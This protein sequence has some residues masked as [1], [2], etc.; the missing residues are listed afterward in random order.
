MKIDLN[1]LEVLNARK[2]SY[3]PPHFTKTVIDDWYTLTVEEWIKSNTKGRYCYTRMP[4]IDGNDSLKVKT[5][6]GFEEEKEMTF[7]M[8]ACPD[9]RRN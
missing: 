8:L 2:L 7:F 4:Y 3:M 9:I 1:P 6:I 5:F